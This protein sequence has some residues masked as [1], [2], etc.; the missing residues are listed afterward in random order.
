MYSLVKI[1]SFANKSFFEFTKAEAKEYLRWFLSIKDERVSVLEANIKQIYPEWK[2]DYTIESLVILYGWFEKQVG[3]RSI[4]EEEK[5][6]FDSQISKTPLFVE[7]IAMPQSTFTDET[8]SVCFDSAIY[9]GEMVIKSIHGVKWLQKL[10]ST[11]YIDYAQPLIGKKESKILINTRRIIEFTA[12][13]ILNKNDEKLTFEM[14][15]KSWFK[16]FNR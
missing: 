1:P 7:V 11:N 8:V 2:A 15:Y 10:S 5:K 13:Q 6:E 3:Y 9:I 12:M 14:I 4:I 16:E